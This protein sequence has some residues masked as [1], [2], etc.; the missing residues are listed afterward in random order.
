MFLLVGC[1][2]QSR[3]K[4]YFPEF[5]EENKAMLWFATVALCVSL[6]IRGL[7]DT[8]RYFSPDFDDWLNFSETAYN[9]FTFVFCDIVPICFQL[10]T[11]IFGYIRKKKEDK[12]SGH[13]T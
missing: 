9:F 10:S 3:L 1:S 8:G 4:A 6:M 13:K 5:Y 12:Y 11:L 2:I 7:L